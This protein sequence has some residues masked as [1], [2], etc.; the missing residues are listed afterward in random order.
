MRYGLDVIAQHQL[1]WVRGEVGLIVEVVDLVLAGKV[2]LEPFIERRR[3]LLTDRMNKFFN[4]WYYR[5]RQN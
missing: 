3:D 2:A 4:A 1:F 5:N